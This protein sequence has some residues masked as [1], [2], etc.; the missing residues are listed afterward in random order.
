MTPLAHRILSR[1]RYTE[2]APNP[3]L[4][5]S[6]LAATAAGILVTYMALGQRLALLA[7]AVAVITLL[8][9]LPGRLGVLAVLMLTLAALSATH[10]LPQHPRPAAVPA[11]VAHSTR[12]A[13]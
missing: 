1:R 2:R 13:P 10:R 12:S 5:A 4:P 3:L 7:G 6:L 9:K 8:T 11:A